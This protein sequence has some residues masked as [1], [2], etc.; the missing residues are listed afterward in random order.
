M[1]F[2]SADL[3]K[4][5][6]EH[7]EAETD[8]LQKITRETYAKVLN[9]RMVSGH[10]Q[11]R[12]LSMV[13]HMIQPK[14]VLEIGT[15]TGYSALCMA[16]AL[17]E[18]GKLITI[19]INEELEDRTRSFLSQSPLSS[20]IDYI[21]GDA[22]T[23]IPKLE[24]TFDLVFIDADKFR[25]SHYFDLVIDKVRS[26]GFILVDNVLW[27]GKVLANEG[28]HVDKDTKAILAFNKKVHD[29]I[30]VSNVLLPI[31][32]GIMMLRKK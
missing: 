4:Y 32:D 10:L 17:S 13:A 16:E 7:T 26:G 1:D 5:V 28:E 27:S 24:T 25:Y 22:A 20:K 30:R 15:F 8:L 18:N 9:P 12:F 2:L 3:Q 19:D 14:Y 6:T 11:G 21:V 31:R 29:D 23:V